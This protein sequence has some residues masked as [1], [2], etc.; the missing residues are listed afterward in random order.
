VVDRVLGRIF[1]SHYREHAD[2][3]AAHVNRADRAVFDFLTG[4]AV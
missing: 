3:V 2:P 4:T 1:R